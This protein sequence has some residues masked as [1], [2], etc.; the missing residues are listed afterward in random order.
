MTE[1][2]IV[3]DDEITAR[4]ILKKYI[5]DVQFLD[6]VGE[7][8]NAIDALAFINT[9]KVDLIFLD[10]EMPKL[11]GINLAKIIDNSTKIIFTTAHREFALEGFELSAVDYLLKPISFERFIKAI[12]KITIEPVRNNYQNNNFIYVKVNKKMIKVDFDELLYI[13][14]LSNY[15]KIHTSNQT[16][17]VYEKMMSI[18]DKLPSS[19]FI[20][21]HKS[22]II[23]TKKIRVYTREY[24]E[25][26]KK[27]LPVSNTYRNILFAFLN[28]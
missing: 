7:F 2:C 22:Y 12:Q 14:G 5:Q 4:N 17:V 20:R 27:H 16:L 18:L 8:K 10:I 3:V 1:K 6:L 25:I 9:N 24:V 26:E 15:V 11:S 21:I 28:K 23:N 19:L 13:E